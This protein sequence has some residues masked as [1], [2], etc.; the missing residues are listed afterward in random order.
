MNDE[1][2]VEIKFWLN[3]CQSLPQKRF[4]A[5]KFL[6]DKMIYTDA[7]SVAC[8]GFTVEI[9]TKIIH[10]MWSSEEALKSSTY[11]EL[12]AVFYNALFLTGGFSK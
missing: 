7:S 6:L 1:A 11:I 9:Y 3:N 8:A 5:K 10:K 2:K 4:F 12:K